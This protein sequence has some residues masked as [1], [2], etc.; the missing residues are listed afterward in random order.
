VFVVYGSSNVRFIE[1]ELIPAL[2][3]QSCRTKLHV[4]AVNYRHPQSLFSAETLAF[5]RGAVEGVTDWSE[6]RGPRH[7]GFGEGV[8]FLFEHAAPGSCFLLVNPDS[9]PM[10]GCIERLLETFYEGNAALVEA[11]QW[12]SEHPKEYEAGTGWTPWASGAFVL[13][14]AEAFRRLE[15]FDPLYFLYNE[16]VDLSWRA[17]LQDMPVV[18]EPRAMCAHF[19][20]LLSYRPTRFYYEHFF[21]VRNFLL[22]AY[23]FFGD[24]GEAAAWRWIEEARLP[25]AFRAKVE[26]SYLELRGQIRRVQAPDAFH[27]DK[28]KILGLNLYH[29]LRRV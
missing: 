28:I 4:H 29:Q 21:S 16:D 27:A 10:P 15:G 2:A 12:P 23:K 24:P 1:A 17:W 19:T 14:A 18:H 22:I 26:E 5:A 11:R 25:T 3:A 7:M 9:M 8:N 13:I 6:G 20:G